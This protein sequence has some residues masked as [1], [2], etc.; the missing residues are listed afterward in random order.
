MPWWPSLIL[1]TRSQPWRYTW[2][3]EGTLLN[4]TP[5]FTVSAFSSKG[6]GEPPRDQR[7]INVITISYRFGRGSLVSSMQWAWRRFGNTLEHPGDTSRCKAKEMMVL[8]LRKLSGTERRW[9]STDVYASTINFCR[10]IDVLPGVWAFYY[11]P[12][13]LPCLCASPLL[14]CFYISHALIS[15]Q[16][17][18]Q[19]HSSSVSIPCL[20]YFLSFEP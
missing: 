2:S 20:P 17:N 13:T 1:Q 8:R 9:N 4:I 19:R 12:L 16:K 5:N 15:G 18:V 3:R 14:V 10:H 7:K 11:S 6:T